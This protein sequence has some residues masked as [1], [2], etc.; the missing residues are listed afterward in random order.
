MP[1]AEI[2]AALTGIRSA[3]DI[4][5][6]MVNLRDAE[7]FRSKSIELQGVVLETLEKAIAAREAQTEQSDRIRSLEAEVA[8][9]KSWD[10]EKQCYELKSIGQG[11]VARILKPEARG[12]E[13]PH[14]LCPNCFE[15]GKKSFLQNANKVER[16]RL[17]VSCVAC[18]LALPILIEITKWPD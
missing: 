17:I 4:T 18:D 6:A 2:T 11:V 1:A 10:A 13:P 15:Q 16:G 12:A 8:S 7:A 5:K 3:L 14:C 9:L